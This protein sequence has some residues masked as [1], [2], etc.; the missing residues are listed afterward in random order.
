MKDQGRTNDEGHVATVPGEQ[1]GQH[2]E[3]A[4]RCLFFLILHVLK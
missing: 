1:V 2:D 4:G 3:G